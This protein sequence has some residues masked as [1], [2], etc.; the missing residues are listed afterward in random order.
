MGVWE[1]P[2]R[3]VILPLGEVCVVNPRR[4]RLSRD[5]D[6][7]TSFVP[8]A[9]VDDDQG[10]I[11]DPQ[12]KPYRE[13]RR[14]YTYFE[15]DDVLFAKITPSMQNGKSAIARGLIDGL[16]FGSTEFHVLRPSSR[17]IPKWVHLFVRQR[18]FRGEAMRHFRGTVGQQRV[19]AD[20]LEDHPFPLPPVDEQ[21]R[22]V[23]RIEEL[24]ARIEEA[25]H[26]RAA[27]DEDA[28]KLLNA[29][30]TEVFWEQSLNLWER[31][32]LKHLAK[33]EAK[34]VDPTLPEY[35]DL[36]HINGNVI[37]SGNCRLLPYNT[38][39]EDGMTSGKYLFGPGDVLYSKIRPYLR[40]A[41]RVDFAGL[42]SADMYPLTVTY[43]R[44]EPR[45]LMWSLVAPPFTDYA[46]ERSV[47]ARMPK[48]NRSQLFAYSFPLPSLDEQCRI[49]EYLDGVQAQVTELKRLQAESAAELERL[50][51]A[52]LARVFRGEL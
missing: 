50:S 6:T 31:T 35:R 16:G 4:P 48:L 45:F 21:R 52:V 36:P 47:R 38:A 25:R 29:T 18:S 34:L 17:V 51:G 37:E 2:E 30:M 10:V 20:F 26:L 44:L 42:C 15:E 3:W 40:K 46:V 28:N 22:I 12:T 13:V 49:V 1:L 14:G 24:F 41:T 43:Q 19:P 39:A 23:A 33:I 8:M 5:D 27:A 7:L 11:A 9:V 32:P